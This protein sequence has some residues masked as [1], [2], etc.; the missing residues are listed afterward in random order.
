MKDEDRTDVIE[1]EIRVP[2]LGE[3]GL[4]NFPPYLMNRIMGRYNAAL[5][6]EMA[7]L[8]LTTPK[9]RSLAVLSV[10]DGL[11]IGELAVYAIAEVSTLSRALDALE[12]DGLVKRVADKDD[13]R[14]VRIHITQKGRETHEQLWP[15]LANA[16]KQMFRGIS[17]AEQRA[18]VAT[19]QTI[20]KNVRK[21]PI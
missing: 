14:A 2:R 7:K 18:F 8:G 4:E 15:H 10:M 12:R 5:R 11:L 6:E 19:L 3:I 20:L 17:D 13:S 21:H 9:M 16:Y 1:A